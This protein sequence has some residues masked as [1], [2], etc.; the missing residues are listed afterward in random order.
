MS[1]QVAGLLQLT[2]LIAALALAYRPLGDYMARVYS[3][4]K[5]YRPEKWMY[6]A[7][8]ANPAAEMRWPAYLRGV[9][10][11]SAMSVLFLY[12]MQ[13]VQGSLPGSLGFSSIDPDQAFNTAASFVA[14]TNWQSY[15][16]EQAMGHVVQTGGLAVQNF[17]SAAV[18]MAVAVALVR[19][20]ARSR[21]GELGNFWADLVRGT[22]RILV[23]I[24]VIGA[25]VLVAAGAI[26]N[27]SGIH[28]VGQFAGG[29]QEWNGGAVASQEAIKELGTNG[30]GYFNANSA[31]P[32][33]N[34]NPLSNL[35]EVFLILLI[36]FALTRTFGRMAGSLKQG[37]AILGAMA[38]IWIGFTALMMW[39]EFA[40][41]GPAFEIA[42]GA[43]EG[44]EARFGIAGS[45]IFAVATTLTSTGAVNSFHS[46]YTGFGGGIT[47]LGMQLGEI[48]P[49]GVGSGLY[50]M[51]IMAIIAV[52]IAGLMVGRTPEYLGKKIGTRQIKF[53]ACYILITPALV[54]G[55]TAV[56][57]AL[58]TPADSMT[59]S[60]AHGFSEI[61]YAYTSGAN[62]NGSAF[63]GLNADTQWFN[64]TIGIAM[65]LGR[66]LPMVFVLALAGSLAE[67]QPVP[68]TAGTL[69]TDKPLYSGLLVG[70]ILIITGLTYFPALALGP[71]A[72][73]LAS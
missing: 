28:Q 4:E 3:S 43:M 33:E 66:F 19:G 61:L 35:F 56:A 31:H 7:I 25:I 14:N 5:H 67:Q 8:G 20:F 32:F 46:S 45:S 26:Q 9:L 73:G 34:P 62:N 57:M 40:H 51:L 44:K 64:T 72:E 48:A 52:F 37:Y 11:F 42:G 17:L 18:G 38:V 12:L 70:T 63:A 15:Y 21:T 50:G 6:K 30:G 27:F 65:L 53:A 69:R 54:L 49:G 60:G 68:E 23:P 16:G 55:F 58:P 22:V 13:R 41:R 10:A 59:N 2:A 29:T 71:L 47:L 36:P 39:T 1:S 24:S